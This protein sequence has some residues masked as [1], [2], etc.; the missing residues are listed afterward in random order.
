MAGEFLYT[1]G[2]AAQLK[3]L[4]QG[5]FLMGRREKRLAFIGRSNV[6]KSTLINALL[7]FKLARVSSEPG[8]TRHI[9][10]YA[11]KEAGKIVAD[12]PGYGFAK[13]SKEDREKWAEFVNAYLQLDEGL[14][15][16]LVLL[17][18]RHGPTDLDLQAIQFLR[19]ECVV[20]MVF[21]MT[22]ID[23][24]KTQ[25]ERA[26]RKKEVER[27]FEEMGYSKDT[28]HWV[29]AKEGNRP[30]SGVDR[31]VKELKSDAPPVKHET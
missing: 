23:Q 29:S 14:E 1:V 28:V 30:G 25:S 10:F 3:E 31:L 18:S 21:V 24:L 2:D 5:P 4:F 8:K 19:D 11:W 6:G 16:A 27:I 15:R 22:K 17:D 13:Q 12:L 9:H 7:S 26:K 20:P